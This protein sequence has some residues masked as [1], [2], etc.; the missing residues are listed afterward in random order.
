MN[1]DG[2]KDRR[3]ARTARVLAISVCL[4]VVGGCASRSKPAADTEPITQ[5]GGEVVTAVEAICYPPNGWTAEPLKRSNRH[6]HQ[7]WLSPSK[8]TAYGVIHFT[9]PWPVGENTVLRAFLREMRKTEGQAE[10]LA[11]TEDPQLPGLR[12]E[13]RGGLY[14]IRGNLTVSGWEGWTVYAGTLTAQPVIP[15]ELT[16]A[17]DARERTL[18][19]Q[20]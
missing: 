3:I 18:I 4:A 1:D 6:T 10:L 13:A 16:Q 17:E 8:S 2:V 15:Q 12:F 19:D 11:K 5:P 20:P 7:I 14:H 9:L